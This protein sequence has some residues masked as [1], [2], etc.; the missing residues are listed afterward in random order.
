MRDESCANT[1]INESHTKLKSKTPKDP[2]YHTFYDS[3]IQN[4][5]DPMQ[6]LNKM[7]ANCPDCI[8]RH[9]KDTL[10]S[11]AKNGELPTYNMA[12]V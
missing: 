5:V 1:T 3:T 4:P 11:F 12:N 7:D 8:A 10:R 2:E 6:K 9:A